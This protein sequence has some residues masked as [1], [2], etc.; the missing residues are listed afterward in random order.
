MG[1]VDW[2]P[3][4]ALG[5]PDHPHRGFETV[6]Y[7]LEGHMQHRD[8]A[9]HGA[10]LG[11][12]DVQ[13]MSAGSGIV[14]SELPQPEFKAAGGRLHGFQIWVN[15]P[16]AHKMT[17]PRYQGI[18]ADEIPTAR[19][20]DGRIGVKVI[21]GESLGATAV[22]NTLSPITYLH[23]TLQ[24]GAALIQPLLAEHQALAYVFAGQVRLGRDHT[25]VAEGQM[26]LTGNGEGLRL[27][28]DQ[29]GTAATELL[30]LAGRPIREPVVRHG[31]FVM[32]TREQILDAIRDYQTGRLGRT[33]QS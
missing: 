1:P 32:N 20:A 16:S 4:E 14:H 26:A 8:S 10:D 19:S 28:V 15:L 13:W 3:G 11:P 29:S 33:T 23:F 18:P 22:T 31:P 12:G 27:A 24:P 2:A 21:A 30:L 6:T 7:L 5:A 17:P 25:V 9:G